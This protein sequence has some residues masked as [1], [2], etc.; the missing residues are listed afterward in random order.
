MI[1]VDAIMTSNLAM[2]RGDA[3]AVGAF[4]VAR[5]AIVPA[6]GARS[7]GLIPPTALCDDSSLALYRIP[8][9]QDD[10][11][12]ALLSLGNNLALH[13][14]EYEGKNMSER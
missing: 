10:L 9:S 12:F 3:A 2:T 1:V 5:A 7:W 6:Q 11:Q 8:F 4:L 13:E 14:C